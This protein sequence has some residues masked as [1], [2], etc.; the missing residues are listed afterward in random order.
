MQLSEIL[1]ILWTSEILP[2]AAKHSM[3]KS[4]MLFEC[5]PLPSLRPLRVHLTPAGHSHGVSALR[6]PCFSLLFCFRV[7]YWTHTEE[8]KRGRPGNEATCWGSTSTDSDVGIVPS[9]VNK[10]SATK[11]AVYHSLE[12]SLEN[13]CGVKFMWFVWSVNLLRLIVTIWTSTLSIPSILVYY[14]VLVAVM[15]WQSRVVLI[16]GLPP[17]MWTC[18]HTYSLIIAM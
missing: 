3:M 11:Q 9:S 13:F 6:L 1:V 2:I 8:Q 12:I 4:S 17:G 10:V 5:G 7:L 18:A 16:R 14:Q 15:L